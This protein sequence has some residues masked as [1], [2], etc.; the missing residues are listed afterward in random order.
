M[1]Q[2]NDTTALLNRYGSLAAE[3][4]DL[5]KPP[6]L[7]PDTAFHLKRFAGFEGE[8]LEPAC[9]SGRTLLPFLQAGLKV[10]GFDASPD[11]LDRCRSRCGAAGLYPDLSLQRLESFVFDRPFAAILMPVGTFNLLDSFDLAMALLRRFF[12][13]LRP[14]GTLVLDLQSL[15]A[16]AE[17]RD[18]QRRWLTPEGDLLT[19]HGSRTQTDWLGQRFEATLRYER[20]RDHRLIEAQMEPMAQRIWGV[21]EFALALKAAGFIDLTIMGGYDRR[22]APVPADRILTFEARRP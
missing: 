19:L 3:I 16:L 2:S 14:G 7:L 18:D 20:W 12:D 11:M 5:D 21:E 22:R 15:A 10:T 17:T 4:Y 13:G 9:G 6:G 1:S 8:I